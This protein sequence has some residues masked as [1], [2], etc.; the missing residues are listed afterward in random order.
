MIESCFSAGNPVG[1]QCTLNASRSAA[2]CAYHGISGANTVY[3]N[4][5]FPIYSSPLPFTCGRAPASASRTWPCA[6]RYWARAVRISSPS[7]AD[8]RRSSW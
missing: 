7:A 1:Q 4:M 6:S 8:G 5:P 2:Y 3:A